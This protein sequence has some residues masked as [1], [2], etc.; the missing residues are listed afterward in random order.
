MSRKILIVDDEKD[1]VDVM[2]SCFEYEGWL[3]ETADNGLEAL[4]K[5]SI[6]SPDVILSDINMPKMNGLQFLAE[7]DRMQS[8]IPLIFLSAF[9]DV[10]KMK[11]A[12]GL[13]AFDFLD[14]PFS[15]RDLLQVANSAYD[16]G[17]D[18]TV[19]A[20]R[21]YRRLKKNAS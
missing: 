19:S 8:E 12:W 6:F 3:V 11:L 14:K 20:R 21:R 17:R 9:R 1:L 2:R 16:Y 13:C 15:Q 7:L 5:C 18:Y 4:K 10:E